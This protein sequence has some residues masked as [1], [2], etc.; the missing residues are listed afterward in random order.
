MELIVWFKDNV[1]ERGKLP[2]D[3]EDPMLLLKTL[4]N[5]VDEWQAKVGLKDFMGQYYDPKWTMIDTYDIVNFKDESFL[6][7][8]AIDGAATYYGYELIKERLNE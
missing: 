8:C 4:V 6:R 1:S 3:Y 7:Y 5:D 2:I